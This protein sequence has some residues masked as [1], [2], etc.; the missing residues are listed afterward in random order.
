MAYRSAYARH[1][2]WE[3]LLGIICGVLLFGVIASAVY[4]MDDPERREA[5]DKA[6]LEC[7]LA[8]GSYENFGT[9]GYHCIPARA[10]NEIAP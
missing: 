10:K 2:A 5:N 7:R 6:S 8:G 4:I 9:Q 1:P 3:A